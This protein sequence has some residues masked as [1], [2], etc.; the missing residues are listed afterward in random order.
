MDI[1]KRLTKEQKGKLLSVLCE[2]AFDGESADHE[3][4][5]YCRYQLGKLDFNKCVGCKLFELDKELFEHGNKN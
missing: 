1:T 5:I 2:F 4:A 3:K